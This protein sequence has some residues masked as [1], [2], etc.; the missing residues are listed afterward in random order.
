MAET[1]SYTESVLMATFLVAQSLNLVEEMTL[2]RENVYTN[3]SMMNILWK[4]PV[5]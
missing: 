4:K 5:R 1:F 3:P 2:L